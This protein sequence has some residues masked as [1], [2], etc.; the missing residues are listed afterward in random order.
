MAAKLSYRRGKPIG[1]IVLNQP[2][3]RNAISAAMWAALS[4]AIGEAEKD[5]DAS[6]IV[7][8]GEGEHF[9]AGADISEFERVYETPASAERYTRTMLTALEA[10]ARC[11]KPTLAAIRGACVGG[12][13]SVALACDFRFADETARFGITPGK[14]GLV[15]PLADTR[16]LVSAVGESNAKDLLM[17]GRLIPAEQALAIGLCDRVEGKV[18][19]SATVS[20]FANELADV[21]RASLR[22]TKEMFAFLKEGAADQDQ[23]A[24]ELLV[25]S[26]GGADF[27][28]GYRAFLE[29]RKPDFPER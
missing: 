2:D 17:S 16:R 21:S 22:A 19:L 25:R 8:R 3:K 7:I 5:A 26:F 1:E 15:Y 24:M 6:L 14:L 29:K 28:E 27:S 12:G 18:T 11:S 10:L 23:R 9:A 4:T 13:C 20:A